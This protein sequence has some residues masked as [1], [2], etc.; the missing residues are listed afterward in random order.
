VLS[1]GFL[2]PIITRLLVDFGSETNIEMNS[3]ALPC[4]CCQKLLVS[5]GN[6]TNLQKIAEQHYSISDRIL[7]GCRFEKETYMHWSAH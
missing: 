5:H 7:A 1:I 6:E 3:V 4:N 2:Y